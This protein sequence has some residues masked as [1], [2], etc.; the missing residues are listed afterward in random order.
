[1]S[2]TK[3][4]CNA[5]KVVGGTLIAI[6]IIWLISSVIYTIFNWNNG[7]SIDFIN[8]A[9]NS[10]SGINTSNA[11]SLKDIKDSITKVITSESFQSIYKYVMEKSGMFGLP[12]TSLLLG[13]VLTKK[14]NGYNNIPLS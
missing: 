8:N 6:S 10:F 13:A 12:L 5:S 4:C 2:S 1:M 14:D 9:T 3:K 7:K 11:T